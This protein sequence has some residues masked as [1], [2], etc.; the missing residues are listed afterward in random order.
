MH[1]R[2]NLKNELLE[3]E[4]EPMLGGISA[5]NYVDAQRSS[6]QKSKS[7]L[8][9][10]GANQHSVKLQQFEEQQR[11]QPSQQQQILELKERLD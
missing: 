1:K 5:L 10:S 7:G 6:A 11:M 2:L 3:D 8:G 9:G 4:E